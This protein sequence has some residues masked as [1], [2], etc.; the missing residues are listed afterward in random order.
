MLVGVGYYIGD[1][2][3]RGDSPGEWIQHLLDCTIDYM[4]ADGLWCANINGR[5][6][7]RMV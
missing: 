5:E 2:N 7:H 1:V 6:L 3:H 4:I